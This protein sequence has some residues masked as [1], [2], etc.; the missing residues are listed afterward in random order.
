[1]H[2]VAWHLLPVVLARRFRTSVRDLVAAAM[3]AQC[4]STTM[5]TVSKMAFAN[6]E[7]WREVIRSWCIKAVVAGGKGHARR[8]A[9][10]PTRTRYGFYGGGA[11]SL[12]ARVF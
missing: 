6:R 3:A 5:I 2:V 10:M 12:L 11:N 8:K 1:M 9:L 4:A 7:I